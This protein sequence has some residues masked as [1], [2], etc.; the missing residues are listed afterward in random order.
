MA[1]A[2]GVDLSAGQSRDQDQ[3]VQ[4]QEVALAQIKTIS[5]NCGQLHVSLN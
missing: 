1:Q 3:E 2:V 5:L 4:P